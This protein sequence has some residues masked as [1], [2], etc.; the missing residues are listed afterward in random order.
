MSFL[1]R[2]ETA[3]T[4]PAPYVFP[5][6][7]T[8]D[9]NDGSWSTFM[10]SVGDAQ[11]DGHSGQNFKVHISTG[12]SVVTIPAQADWCNEPDKDSC[13]EGRGIQTFDAKQSL[14]F[15][16]SSSGSWQEIGI[17][18]LPLPAAVELYP[19]LRPNATYGH[20]TVG[21]GA[22]STL[23]PMLTGQLVAQIITEDFFMGVFG[24]SNTPL[25][26]GGGPIDTFLSDFQN[27]NQTPSLAYGYQAGA[28]YR[29]WPRN[30]AG[31]LGSLTLGGYDQSRFSG[32]G[33]SVPM[34]P[35]NSSLIVG[36]QS[37]T[38][39]P[40]P[41]IESNVYSMTAGTS[42]FLATIDSTLPYLW[43]PDA[44]CDAI[45]DRFR[46]T[47]D[48]N[49]NLYTVNDT[50][51]S[52]NY[53][54]NATMTFT[55]GSGPNP[56]NNVASI[57]LPYAA[58]D[59]TASFPIYDDATKYFPLKR[60]PTGIFVLGRALLQETY[61]IVN[62]EKKNFTVAPANFTNP[63]PESHIVTIY[64]ASYVPPSTT[65]KSGLSTGAKAGIGAG[66][67]VLGLILIGL[68]IWF[69]IRRRR[70]RNK[71]AAPPPPSEIDTLVAGTEV[72]KR[73]IS[74]L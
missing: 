46:L 25:G 33:I 18:N 74:E 35:G 3:K 50:S 22:D 38:V 59:L 66:C 54:Q 31:V 47:Y 12:G 13:A 5:P 45:A 23:S 7:G 71:P 42:G 28:K 9:G 36:V 17:Y 58:L 29:E 63:M 60:S 56:S 8:F 21:L 43:L 1:R 69:F 34:P 14:G 73:R 68:A 70:N 65:K 16:S 49:T 39:A 64:P 37:I 40:D 57:V 26:I 19:D 48:N 6:S 53:N 51:H 55:I 15:A 32:H 2:T 20:D 30:T 10:I 24:L 62:Y 41:N 11:A 27:A 67:G 52:Y 4:I 72:K 61:L 44:I